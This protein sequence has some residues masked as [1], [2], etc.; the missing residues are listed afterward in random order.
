MPLTYQCDIIPAAITPSNLCLTSTRAG[1]PDQSV[2]NIQ[3]TSELLF[4]HPSCTTYALE[5]H[6]VDAALSTCFCS[7][8]DLRCGCSQEPQQLM[9]VWTER[10]AKLSGSSFHLILWWSLAGLQLEVR[11]R[12]TLKLFKAATWYVF[13]QNM[14]L[15]LVDF[16]A[17]V[18]SWCL[19]SPP[20]VSHNL[21]G[22]WR[23]RY[24][25]RTW[26]S[27]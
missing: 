22:K 13:N 10:R 4:L 8:L 25:A 12:I 26:M 1:R 18:K 27:Q 9:A 3:I 21:F 16:T 5:K 6:T 14:L 7:L 19:L 15:S 20:H 23:S 24:Q 17:H 2:W 11:R